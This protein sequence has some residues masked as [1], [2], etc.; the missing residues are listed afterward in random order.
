[1]YVAIGIVTPYTFVDRYKNTE[2]L[3]SLY[4]LTL[5]MFIVGFFFVFTRERTQPM[6][7][8]SHTAYHIRVSEMNQ[9]AT[10]TW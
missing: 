8:Y 6:S 2:M 9:I 3:V 5:F 10:D 7:L 1:M 4:Q